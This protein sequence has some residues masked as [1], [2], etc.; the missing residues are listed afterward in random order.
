M[1]DKKVTQDSRIRYELLQGIPFVNY[2]KVIDCSNE[3][4]LCY[5]IFGKLKMS[6]YVIFAHILILLI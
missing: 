1:S 4:G 5:S 3:T 6:L 2:Q